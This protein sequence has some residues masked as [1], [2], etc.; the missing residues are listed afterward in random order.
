MSHGIR[1]CAIGI[2]VATDITRTVNKGIDADIDKGI[3]AA[4]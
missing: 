3:Y 4:P 2:T 1:S